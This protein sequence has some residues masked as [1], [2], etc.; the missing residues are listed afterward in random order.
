MRKPPRSPCTRSLFTLLAALALACEREPTDTVPDLSGSWTG[1]NSVAALDLQMSNGSA[2][3][4]C[5]PFE[6]GCNGPQMIEVIRASGT[7]TDLR[8]GAAYSFSDQTQRRR[9]GL[10]LF[11]VYAHDDFSG[12]QNVAT[13]SKTLLVG[14]TVDATTIDATLHTEYMRSSGGNSISW[15]TWS[16]DSSRLTLRRR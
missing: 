16:A 14:R 1:R 5:A 3:H 8:T 7:F 13:Y 6:F 12:P 10:V 9:D 15:T 4:S 2:S 11:I